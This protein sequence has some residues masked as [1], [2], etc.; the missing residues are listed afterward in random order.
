MNSRLAVVYASLEVGLISNCLI[1]LI[2]SFFKFFDLRE[3]TLLILPGSPFSQ[4]LL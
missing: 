1:I 4:R 2:L 3:K